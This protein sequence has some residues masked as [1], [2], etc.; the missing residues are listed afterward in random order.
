MFGDDRA[1]LRGFFLRVYARAR[2]GEVLEPLESLVGNVIDMHPEYH[3]VL[4]DAESLHRDRFPGARDG[5]P[6]LHMAMHVTIAEQLGSDRPAGLR[7]AYLKAAEVHPD[8]HHL[9]H[10]IMECLGQTMWQA[11]QHDAV[12]DEQAYL[13]CVQRLATRAKAPR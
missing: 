13:R 5:N 6:F 8:N 12:P 11:Q 2:A 3:P 7:D 10:A 4:A 1:R 9:E